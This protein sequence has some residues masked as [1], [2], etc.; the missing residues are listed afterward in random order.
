MV[1][2]VEDNGCHKI[3]V[4]VLLLGFTPS[5]LHIGLSSRLVLASWKMVSVNGSDLL[6]AQR[7]EAPLL[8]LVRMM[9]SMTMAKM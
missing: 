5:P 7:G 8:V 2:L 1:P 4:A 6:D 9:V 3:K